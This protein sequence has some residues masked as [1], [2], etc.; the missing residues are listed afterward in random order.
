MLRF[1]VYAVLLYIVWKIVKL[2]I[3]VKGTPRRDQAPPV[4]FPQDQSYKNIEDA[5]F[6]DVTG[7]PDK[8]S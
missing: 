2:F 7:D 8:P 6:E 3:A 4:D 5:D 1:L